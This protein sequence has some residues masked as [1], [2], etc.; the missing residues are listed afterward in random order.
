V[1]STT[2][3][4]RKLRLPFLFFPLFPPTFPFP[5]PFPHLLSHFFL[6]SLRL[7]V[8]ICSVELIFFPHLLFVLTVKVHEPYSPSK[9]A[10][11]EKGTSWLIKCPSEG[12]L[13]DVGHFNTSPHVWQLM[14]KH[15]DNNGRDRPIIARNLWL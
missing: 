3:H 14:T 7:S 9:D 10:L 4:G 2:L 13:S 6:S 12:N 15:V 11:R 1:N 8:S 5:F